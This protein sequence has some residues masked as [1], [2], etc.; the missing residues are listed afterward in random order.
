[1]P[2]DVP[3]SDFTQKQLLY[4]IVKESDVPPGSWCVSC[5]PEPEA[6]GIVLQSTRQP[7]LLTQQESLEGER[8]SP[9][10]P[11]FP[12]CGGFAPVCTRAARLFTSCTGMRGV[13]VARRP[14][15]LSARQS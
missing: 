7:H 3:P 4:S 10:L 15:M 9:L 2:K 13:L 11:A 12:L 5:L 6:Q 1:M 8:T 14:V